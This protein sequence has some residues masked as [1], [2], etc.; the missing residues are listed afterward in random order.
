[1]HTRPRGV[2]NTNIIYVRF[3]D[4]YFRYIYTRM[5]STFVV[6]MRLRGW[7]FLEVYLDNPFGPR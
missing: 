3:A 7:L 1:M 6:V 4:M 5:N 2:P